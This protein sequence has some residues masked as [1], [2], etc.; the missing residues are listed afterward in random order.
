[1][2]KSLRKY[3][4]ES[5]LVIKQSMFNRDPINVDAKRLTEGAIAVCR[6]LHI[7]QEDLLDKTMEDFQNEIF[8]KE[9]KVP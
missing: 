9:K 3:S 7:N 5:S 2:T 4:G 6:D 1:M 8:K